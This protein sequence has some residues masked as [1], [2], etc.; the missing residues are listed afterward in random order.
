M[1]GIV[2]VMCLIAAFAIGMLAFC[3]ETKA[4]GCVGCVGVQQFAYGQAFVQPFSQGVVL[5][6]V[7]PVYGQA[8]VHPQ[9]VVVN[10]QRVVVQRQRFA[11]PVVAPRV[12]VNTRGLFGRR[13]QVN[14]FR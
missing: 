7:A 3:S 12:Q 9:S 4:G 8:F 10:R 14:V 13:T 6:Q 2:S 5:Q 1:K 11:Q